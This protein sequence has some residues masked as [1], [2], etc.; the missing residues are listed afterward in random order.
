MQ[1]HI[2]DEPEHKTD[3]DTVRVEFA[4]SDVLQDKEEVEPSDDSPRNPQNWSEWKK[5]TQILLSCFHALM[6]G[7]MAAG[8]IPAYGALSERFHISLP[9]ASYLVSSQVHASSFFHSFVVVAAHPSQN[10]VLVSNRLLNWRRSLSLAFHRQYGTHSPSITVVSTCTF[11]RW[12][13]AW[14]ATSARRGVTASRRS[15]P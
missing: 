15:W 4:N 7:F 10:S 2:P 5:N 11:T 8:L 3:D 14:C 6:A 13:A 9:Q 1:N 12:Q